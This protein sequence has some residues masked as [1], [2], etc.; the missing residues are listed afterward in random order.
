MN[1]ALNGLL[2]II[3]SITSA[4]AQDT[5]LTYLQAKDR[6]IKKNF[7]LLAA[8]FEIDQAEAQVIQS[9]LYYN[10]T[11]YW[12]Q[13]AYNRTQEKYLKTSNQY[14]GQINQTIAIAG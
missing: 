11:I 14:E 13:E 3:L 10:P 5:V 9:K 12:N 6:L 2:I 7:Y 4:Q 1:R 8:H